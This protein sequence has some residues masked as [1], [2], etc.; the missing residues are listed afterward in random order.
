MYGDAHWMAAAAYNGPTRFRQ[1]E[2]CR[3]Q[4]Y[5]DGE[6]TFDDDAT[7]NEVECPDCF[8]KG[9]DYFPL[10]ALSYDALPRLAKARREYLRDRNDT[11]P[12]WPATFGSWPARCEYAAQQYGK[13]LAEATSPVHLPRD[14]RPVQWRSAA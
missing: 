3:G 11:R 4:G 1:C 13:A 7:A 2:T 10:H 12:A 9:G 5:V 14:I 8:G 6:A